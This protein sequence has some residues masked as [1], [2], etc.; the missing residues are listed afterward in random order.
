ML[1]PFTAQQI[2]GKQC[3]RAFVVILKL[4]ALVYG[5]VREQQAQHLLQKTFLI[6]L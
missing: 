6:L 3:K 4:A 1:F 5:Q 2:G